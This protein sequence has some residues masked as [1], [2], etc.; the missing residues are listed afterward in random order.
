VRIAITGGAGFLGSRLAGALLDRGTLSVAGAP[1]ADVTT[2]RLLDRVAPSDRLLAD[3]RIDA[4]VGDLTTQLAAETLRDVD[5]VVHLA[6]TV[7]GEAERNFDDGLANNLDASRALF[8]TC[9]RQTRPP[10]LVFASSIAV[11]GAAPG[12][13]LPAQVC[14]DTL[15]IPQSSY[16]VQKFIIEQLLSDYTRRGYVRGRNVR[17]MTVTVRPGLPNAAASSFVSGIIRE[18]LN[19]ERTVCPVPDSTMVAVSSPQGAID[20]LLC[21][22]T[23]SERAWGSSVAVNLPALTVTPR[24]MVAAMDRVVGRPASAL[25]EWTV[26]PAI[27]DV[28]TTWPARFLTARANALGL[29]A[30]PDFDTI[31][32]SYLHDVDDGST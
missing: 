31:L 28:V 30:E 29:V 12:Y 1:I 5:V 11:F 6:A 21:A 24:E 4:V 25:V 32:R 3:G 10:V 13:P 22:T 17:L 15:P 2:I 18:P 26:D 19:G 16:G 9:R 14:D 8:E 20:G 23:A 7:S 27:V